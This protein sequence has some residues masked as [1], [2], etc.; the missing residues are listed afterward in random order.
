VLAIAAALALVLGVS[1]QGG[2]TTPRAA[3]ELIDPVN[4]RVVT[5][6][7]TVVLEDPD[8]LFLPEGAVVSV[9]EGGSARI[10][11]TVL[12]AG[13][14]ATV[15]GGRL[16]VDHLPVRVVPTPS[17][18]GPGDQPVATPTPSPPAATASPAPVRTP[19]PIPSPE[20]TPARTPGSTPRP[21][22]TGASP[23]P[24]RPP[25]TVRPRLRCLIDGRGSR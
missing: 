7:G 13:D 24:T 21:P 5:A 9:G 23:T 16:V 8:G 1:S 19:G 22:A 10:G 6:D 18:V 17:R 2:P 20:P 14:V 4:V 11:D 25:A 15:Q 12:A 3:A